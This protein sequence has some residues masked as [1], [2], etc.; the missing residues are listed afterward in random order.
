MYA[1]VHGRSQALLLSAIAGLA[2][3]AAFEIGIRGSVPDNS[4]AV[5]VVNYIAG[6]DEMVF[7]DVSRMVRH[8][9]RKIMLMD[10]VCERVLGRNDYIFKKAW[11]RRRDVCKPASACQ[12]CPSISE[13]LRRLPAHLDRVRFFVSEFGIDRRY[14]GP[15]SRCC[16]RRMSTLS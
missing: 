7:R 11:F 10:L 15:D 4:H 9:A 8:Q 2:R 13:A 16:I 12:L 3:I 1:L 14:C 5:D 6:N